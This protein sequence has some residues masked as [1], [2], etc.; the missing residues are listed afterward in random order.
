MCLIHSFTLTEC[1]E[2]KLFVGRYGAKYGHLTKWKCKGCNKEINRKIFKGEYGWKTVQN[3]LK[4][5][6]K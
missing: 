6:L 5:I 4:R 1:S 2:E 3:F